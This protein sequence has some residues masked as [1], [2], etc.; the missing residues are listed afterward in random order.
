MCV[1]LN[2]NDDDFKTI[3]QDSLCEVDRQ[4]KRVTLKE[5]CDKPNF[6]GHIQ[7]RVTC[8]WK[9]KPFDRRR[10]SEWKCLVCYG[11]KVVTLS[12]RNGSQ[13]NCC[14]VGLG[15]PSCKTEWEP[16]QSAWADCSSGVWHV[17]THSMALTAISQGLPASQPF[18]WLRVFPPF[19]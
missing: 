1:V 2:V 11:L 3:F 12:T 4:H 14:S 15:A 10:A 6:L 16:G 17:I 19:M 5:G 8:C 13:A 9:E 7:L 18:A